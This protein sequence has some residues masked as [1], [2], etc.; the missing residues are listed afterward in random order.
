MDDHHET[1]A[2]STTVILSSN[3][4]PSF[5]LDD[6]SIFSLSVG[7]VESADQDDVAVDNGR[8]TSKENV[9]HH[10]WSDERSSSLMV[11][12]SKNHECI[13]TTNGQKKNENDDDDCNESS[14]NQPSTDDIGKCGYFIEFFT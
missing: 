7:F 9:M 11:N 6:S 1:L 14:L 4:S 2:E 12:Q 10:H 5:A 13:T 3:V 8:S